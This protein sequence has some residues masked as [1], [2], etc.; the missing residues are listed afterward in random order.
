MI[1][2]RLRGAGKAKYREFGPVSQALGP[3]ALSSA[4]SRVIGGRF[5]LFMNAETLEV[6][7]KAANGM[8]IQIIVDNSLADHEW[9]V[10]C[11][12]KRIGSKPF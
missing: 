4:L 11:G 3:M 2:D 1:G 5:A 12:D 6:A 10:Q 8:P 7:H 9:Y